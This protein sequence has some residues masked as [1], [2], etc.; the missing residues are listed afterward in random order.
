[1]QEYVCTTCGE[2]GTIQDV[3]FYQI[4]NNVVNKNRNKRVCQFCYLTANPLEAKI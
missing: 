3:A 4:G 1:M 2:R